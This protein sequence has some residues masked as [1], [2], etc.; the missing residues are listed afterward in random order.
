[1]TKVVLHSVP[2]E[3]VKKSDGT[4]MLTMG[5]HT[6]SIIA[7]AKGGFTCTKDSKMAYHFAKAFRVKPIVMI[8]LLSGEVD[9]TVEGDTV[10][11]E[12]PD[13]EVSND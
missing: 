2:S 4:S 13:E 11:F 1:M 9:Y 12:W 5:M 7:W 8:A 6:P 3:E 10:V